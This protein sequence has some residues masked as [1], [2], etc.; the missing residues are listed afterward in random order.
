MNMRN[1]DCVVAGRL[2][3]Y[4]EMGFGRQPLFV[5]NQSELQFSITVISDTPESLGSMG[6][7]TCWG[8]RLQQ[9][10]FV[11]D[12][13]LSEPERIQRLEELLTEK[14]ILF[15]PL[16]RVDASRNERY[17]VAEPVA[18]LSASVE[19]AGAQRLVPLLH[20]NTNSESFAEIVLNRRPVSA[21]RVFLSGMPTPDPISVLVADQSGYVMYGNFE[22]MRPEFSKWVVTGEDIQRMNL[23]LG[24][25]ERFVLPYQ[26]VAF[27]EAD[28]YERL[29]RNGSAEQWEAVVASE[30]PGQVEDSPAPEAGETAVEANS[31]AA[32]TA[33]AL[34]AASTETSAA[35]VLPEKPISAVAPATSAT[36]AA[37]SAAADV[38]VDISGKSGQDAH[39]SQLAEEEFI[40]HLS[41][42]AVAKGLLYDLD[43][44]ISFH[45]ALKTGRLVLL[46]GMSGT[47]KSR[48]ANLYGEALGLSPDQ[49][50]MLS[51]Q[52]TWTDDGDILG[53]LDLSTHVYRPADTGLV[54]L[55]VTAERNPDQLFLVIFDEMNLARVEHY[56]SQF[57]STLEAEDDK[58]QIRLYHDRL[59]DRVYNSSLYPARINV[60]SNV[61]FVG[62]VNVDESTYAFSDKVL[63]RASVIRPKVAP[64]AQLQSQLTGEMPSVGHLTVSHSGYDSWRRSQRA[65]QLMPREIAFLSE[66]HELLQA[67]DLQMGIGYRTLRQISDYIHNIPVGADDSTMVERTAALDGQLV[68]KVFT[69]LRGPQEQLG[70]II[71]RYIDSDRVEDSSLLK[72]M[73]DYQDVSSFALSRKELEHKAREL[74]YYGYTS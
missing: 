70:S 43:D 14:I 45:T 35:V 64:F 51:V 9:Y 26:D 22:H 55:L 20:V 47:G 63:D 39:L 49:H 60:G 13:S 33:A 59:E 31:G 41:S 53:F 52:P 7:Y 23:D 10:G 5:N 11:D 71:G 68:Q 42:L 2:A 6:P 67:I 69:K 3:R 29:Y 27:I 16:E 36:P 32:E 34:G 56:F 44:L 28:A 58:R 8:T 72:L 4:D 15:R 17:Y 65:L 40:N 25:V 37:E 46:S 57:L 30:A 24:F 48:L 18:V 73:D 66:V 1:Y 21:S 74:K 12:K 19:V 38:L 61:L 54:D 62:T 50:L